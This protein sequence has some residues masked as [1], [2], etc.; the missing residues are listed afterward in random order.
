MRCRRTSVFRSTVI[1]IIGLAVCSGLAASRNGVGV[2]Q[3]R[4]DFSGTWTLDDAASSLAIP[5]PR[6]PPPG[7]PPPPPPPTPKA[8]AIRQSGNDL[9]IDRTL[10]GE[11]NRTSTNKLLFY[12]DGSESTN[13]VGPIL[14]KSKASWEGTTLVFSTTNSVEDTRLPDLRETYAVDGD[15]LVVTES[16][17]TPRGA[18]ERRFV[19]RR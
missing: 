7:V 10:V 18:V 12:L 9:A 19:Y 15:R 2:A 3:S 6:Q 5:P 8:L 13:H 1:A 14:G 16:R 11:G 4:P 17:T